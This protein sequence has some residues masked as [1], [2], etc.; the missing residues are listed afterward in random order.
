MDA[1]DDEIG[2]WIARHDAAEAMRLVLE[3]DVVVGPI[4]DAADIMGDPHLRAR[5]DI[6]RVPDGDGGSLA[7][8]AVLP[9][10]DT[11]P[12][13]IGRLGPKLGEDTAAVL[14]TIGFSRRQIDELKAC[15]AVA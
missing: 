9:K 7:M 6:A 10:I 8:P 14:E 15:G 12:G 4:Y 2:A 13:G 1:L 3:N 11:M 5:G